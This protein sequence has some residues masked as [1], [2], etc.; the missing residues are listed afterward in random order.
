MATGKS[1]HCD[2]IIPRADGGSNDPENLQLLCIKCH[3]EK[4]AEEKEGGYGNSCPVYHS[5]FAPSVYEH[6]LP[7]IHPLAFVEVVANH[8]EDV[9]YLLQCGSEVAE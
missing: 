5:Q 2:H 1:C 6:V 3:L 7:H 9:K 4:C 8:I